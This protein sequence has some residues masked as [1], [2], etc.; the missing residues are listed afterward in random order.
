MTQSKFKCLFC[1][2]EVIYIRHSRERKFCCGSHR[3]MFFQDAK[4]HK[5][6]L[7]EK[8]IDHRSILCRK[9]AKQK[10]KHPNWKG[11]ITEENHRIRLS[12]EYRLWRE[13]VLARD[14]W[15]CQICGKRGGDM[16]SHHI[17]KF[18]KFPELRFAIDNGLTLCVGCHRRIEMKG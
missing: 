11:G 8:I 12:I 13:A 18:A 1:G 16:E 17:K 3:Q 14:N 15:T 10:D 5:C 6:L 2:K 7:C 9:C 4:R